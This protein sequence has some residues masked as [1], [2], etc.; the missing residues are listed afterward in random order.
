ME[1]KLARARQ[2][3]DSCSEDWDR[4]PTWRK[5]KEF[6]GQKCHEPR[7]QD[8]HP[9]HSNRI[10]PIFQAVSF[11]LLQVMA[12]P[13]GLHYLHCCSD[14]TKQGEVLENSHIPRWSIAE[15]AAVLHFLRHLRLRM[16]RCSPVFTHCLLSLPI[17]CMGL[18]DYPA[19]PQNHSLSFCCRPMA[20]QR[21]SCLPGSAGEPLAITC[22]YKIDSFRLSSSPLYCP[23]SRYWATSKQSGSQYTKICQDCKCKE[24]ST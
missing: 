16:H 11:S 15:I 6:R 24:V 12:L 8:K 10:V 4:C 9:K 1:T 21:R 17:C 14:W 18:I 20:A 23:F 5:V 2:K 19:W 13:Q 7:S 3:S 22:F